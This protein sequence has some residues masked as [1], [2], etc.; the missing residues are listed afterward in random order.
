MNN[1]VVIAPHPDD[2]TLGVGGTLL[3]EK[4][5][6]SDIHWIIVTSISTEEGWNRE[7]VSSRKKE[8]EIVSNKNNFNSVHDLEIP[9]TKLD[10][11]S[12]SSIIENINNIIVKIKPNIMYIPHYSDIHTD[13]Q[14]VFKASIACSKWFK[15]SYI[16]RCY[17][18]ETLSETH[19][20]QNNGFFK[21]NV[22]V[23][24]SSFIDEKINIMKLYESE[25]HESPHPR[26]ESSIRAL[27]TFRGSMCGYFSAESF[28][29][30][31]DR[32][33]N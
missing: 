12:M 8:I 20:S 4:K 13:H 11:H 23:D 26:S 18:Y 16:D 31:F 2:E 22:F 5:A 10:T 14:V 3:K 15:N 33:S 17:A 19:C 30:L 24:I 28:Q 6:G 27:A 32:I 21:P 29:L 25:M 7:L 1:I 9:T